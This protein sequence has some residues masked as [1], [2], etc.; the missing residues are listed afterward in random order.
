MATILLVEDDESVRAFVS[1]ALRIDRH[2]VIEAEDGEMGLQAFAESSGIDL[3]LSDIQMPV[4][5]G[6]AMTKALAQDRRGQKIL[7]MTG[8]ANQR[9][10]ASD[11]E[12]M[13]LGLV[14]KPFTL[15]A[16][17]DRVSQALQN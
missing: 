14:E 3:V 15:A 6:I 10:R 12:A 7:L 1:K 16:I 9:E 8:Y 11:L 4:M 17:R 13:I 5:D 2:Q